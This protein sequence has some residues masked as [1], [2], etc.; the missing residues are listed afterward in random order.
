MVLALPLSQQV[1]AKPLLSET[2]VKLASEHTE[3]RKGGIEEAM[4]Q[5]PQKAGEILKPDD[6]AKIQRYLFIE[7]QIRFRCPKIKL[8][9]LKEPDSSKSKKDGSDDAKRKPPKKPQGSLAPPSNQNTVSQL[10]GRG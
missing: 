1:A 4:N 8:P 10:D 2:C 7:G 9:G 3:L 6:L 5:D